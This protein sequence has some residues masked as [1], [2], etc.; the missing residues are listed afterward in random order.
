MELWQIL[1]I[2]GIGL[3]IIPGIAYAAGRQLAQGF[4]DQFAK[5]IIKNKKTHQNQNRKKE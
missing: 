2:I 1:L 3:L 4:F 5:F